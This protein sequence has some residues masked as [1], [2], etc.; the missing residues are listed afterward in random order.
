MITLPCLLAGCTGKRRIGMLIRNQP[1]DYAESDTADLPIAALAV[2]LMLG[3]CFTAAPPSGICAA[4]G[5]EPHPPA[6]RM[7]HTSGVRLRSA[8]R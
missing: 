5:L 1:G 4:H 2:G 7:R 6:G 3:G 8:A